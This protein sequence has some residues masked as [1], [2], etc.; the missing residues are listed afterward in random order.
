MTGTTDIAVTGFQF[1]SFQNCPAF[2]KLPEKQIS[3][4]DYIIFKD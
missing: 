3:L 2:F 4:R 1:V